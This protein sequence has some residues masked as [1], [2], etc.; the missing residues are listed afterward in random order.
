M[1]ALTTDSVSRNSEFGAR[2][3]RV[4]LWNGLSVAEELAVLSDGA[5]WI[6]NICEEILPGRNATFTFDLFHALE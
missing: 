6:Q 4:G 1:S 5:L 3:K 2:P